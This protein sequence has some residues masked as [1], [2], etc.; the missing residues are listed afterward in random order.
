[1]QFVHQALTWG[2]LL[3]LV[4]L[5]IHLINM[6]RHRRVRWAAM[7]FLLQ[8]YKKHRKWI[9][10]KQLLLLLTRMAAVALLVAMLAQWV[11]R[12]E[13]LN[14]FG[15]K[16]THHYVLLDD[17]FS[18][19]DRAGGASAF[20][21]ALGAIQR[22]GSQAASQDSLQKFTLIRLSR[23]ARLDGA[24]GEDRN[25]AEIAD[26][27]A[28]IVAPNFD[29]TLEQKRNTFQVTELAVGPTAALAALVRLVEDSGDENRVVYVVSDFRA[30]PWESPAEI[31]E[32]LRQLEQSP[33]SIQLISCV[34]T[35]RQNLAIADIQ[36]AQE[37]QAAGV[38]LFVNVTVKNFGLSLARNVQLNVKTTFYDTEAQQLENPGQVVGKVDELPTVLIEEIE[39]G[40][41]VTRRVQAFFP[42]PGRHVVEATLPEDAVAA[43]NRRWCVIDFPAN[44]PVLIIDGSPE[45]R[46]A[47][48]LASAFR[49]GGRANTG[50]QPEIKTPDFL[51]DATL[52][53]LQGYHAIFL[54]D[55]PRLDDR[56]IENLELYATAGGGVAFFMGPEIDLAFYTNRLYRSGTGLF[57]LPLE[58]ED[59]LPMV[60]VREAP[61]IEVTD[62]PVFEVFLG[63]R[64]P[65]IRLITVE[66][67]LRPSLNWKPEPD[68]NVQVAASLRN[69][70]PLV[71][72]R[73]FGEG[74]VVAF[75]TTVEPGWNNWGND[76]SFVVVALKLQSYL[77]AGRRAFDSRPVGTP[78]VVQLEVDKFR[79]D[80][81]FIA[82]GETP[83]TRTVIERAAVRP[84][85]DSPVMA[86]AI[87]LGM[88]DGEVQTD[89]SGIYEA[90]PVTTGGQADVRRF[91][92][93]VDPE[94]GDLRIVESK[95]LLAA[96]DPV[97]AEFRPAEE[98]TYELAGLGGNNRSLLLM[99]LLL[100]LLIAEQALAYSA[101]YHPTPV[102][103]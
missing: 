82:P 59:I 33:A 78:I 95:N 76:P 45:Q 22:I 71:V 62:H 10:L 49:P 30:N 34:Q 4:P 19:S 53:V 37:T 64:N 3:V 25:V 93:N 58:R 36:P 94:E 5:L 81:Q 6:M 84:Q 1:M 77:A 54:L 65:F 99:A 32:K 16:A 28:E 31:R 38:P 98:F 42:K 51:R 103:T 61:D 29:V 35:V 100:A 13:W 44:E 102:K 88:I 43:D 23:A 47:Y 15:G 86:A 79:Q 14:L 70:M 72:E 75:L 85:S 92:L 24:S 12:G 56:A 90:W 55:V 89:R 41:S 101:S 73:K 91:A 87:G 11:T 2:F 17:S 80:M 60:E 9:W 21:S 18:M 69:G 66:Q 20:E 96:L 52:Q 97:K 8:A 40:Q 68:S 57:P 39:P 7:D 50:I 48:F 67:Y 74:R 26:F 46:H 27:N 83:E 63:E